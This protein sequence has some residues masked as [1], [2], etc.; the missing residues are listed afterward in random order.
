MTKDS[1]NTANSMWG[2]HYTQGPAEVMARINASI[3]VDKALYSQ[4]IAGS[5]AHCQMLAGQGILSQ[6][7][8][9]HRHRLDEFLRHE[10]L[11]RSPSIPAVYKLLATEAWLRAR[12][13]SSP[14]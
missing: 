10:R 4:D 7:D 5:Q 3:D 11:Q 2:G 13:H 12:H 6:Q 14:K 9:I 1:T 8:F